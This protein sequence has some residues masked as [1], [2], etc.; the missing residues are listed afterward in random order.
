MLDDA[1]PRLV[2]G[3]MDMWSFFS[4]FVTIVAIALRRV[5]VVR[6]LAVMVLLWIGVQHYL[7][8]RQVDRML[9]QVDTPSAPHRT[10]KPDVD[11]GELRRVLRRTPAGFVAFLCAGVLALVPVG[12]RP[13]DDP[14]TDT[15]SDERAA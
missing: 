7:D 1:T 8:I 5:V 14:E 6:V 11:A 9:M 4:L 15:R 2:V 3:G 13:S 12:R 10:A